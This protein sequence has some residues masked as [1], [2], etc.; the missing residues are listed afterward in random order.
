MITFDEWQK[1]ELKTAKIISAEDIPGKDKLYK[2]GIDLGSEKRTL[3]AGIK[4]FY[5]KE[6]LEGKTILVIANLA[7]A[8]IAGIESKGML[9]AVKNSE[10]KY[11]LVT[12]DGEAAPGTRAE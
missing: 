5:T 3:V 9:L 10:G 1:V 7:P 8:M 12:T 11:S 4:H 6:Q 2:L